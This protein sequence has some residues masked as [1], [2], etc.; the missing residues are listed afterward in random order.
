MVMVAYAKPSATVSADDLRAHIASRLAAYKV[1]NT[2]ELVNEPLPQNAS[3]KLF[4]RK[5]R[6]EYIA[7]NP[8]GS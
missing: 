4:K 2:I 1:P 5:I 7:A 8:P 3:G 6:D